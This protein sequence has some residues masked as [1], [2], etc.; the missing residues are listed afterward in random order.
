MPNAR[1]LGLGFAR[2]FS[3]EE[4][5]QEAHHDYEKAVDGFGTDGHARLE[6]ITYYVDKDEWAA[7]VV[8][9]EL[10]G[11]TSYEANSPGGI[12]SYVIQ[13]LKTDRQEKDGRLETKNVSVS[14]RFTCDVMVVITVPIGA[15]QHQIKVAAEEE[16]STKDW[17]EWDPTDSELVHV[18]DGEEYIY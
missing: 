15:S 10:D 8:H 18:V 9:N 13:W 7:V 5:S 11:T 2:V 3:G 6:R 12:L 14:M 17:S 16:A 1:L 4:A